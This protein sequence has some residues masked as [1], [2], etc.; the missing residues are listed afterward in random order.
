MIQ[1]LPQSETRT[2]YLTGVRVGNLS[3]F[4]V[5]FSRKILVKN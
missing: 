2:L 1:T 5:R 4:G 3:S